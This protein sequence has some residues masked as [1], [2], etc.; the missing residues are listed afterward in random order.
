M[1]DF[2]TL[3][4]M[5]ISRFDEIT[6]YSL[7]QDGKTR[8]ILRVYYKRKKGSVLP[9]RKT[10]KFGRASKMILDRNS[11]TGSVEIYEISPFL[12]KALHELD[13][14]VERR[15]SSKDISE[16]LLKRIDNLE[17]DVK[18]STDEM[19]ALVASL[20]KNI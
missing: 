3:A 18:A 5:D 14:I 6:H 2:P 13:Q 9:D 11:S 7:R 1:S 20:K 10:F 12:Q 19:R 16:V 15:H 4:E 8:D 17:K